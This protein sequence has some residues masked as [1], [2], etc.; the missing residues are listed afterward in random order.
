MENNNT[1]QNVSFENLKQLGRILQENQISQ[2]INNG[3]NAKKKLDE[4]GV[5]IRNRLVSL[6]QP[7]PETPKHIAPQ[8]S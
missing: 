1:K 4:Y 3:R 5:V 2:I 6:N 8:T 7:V